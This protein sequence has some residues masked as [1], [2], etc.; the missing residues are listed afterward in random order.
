[1]CPSGA[2]RGRRRRLTVVG[3]SAATAVGLVVTVPALLSGV[4]RRANEVS[5]VASMLAIVA[6]VAGAALAGRLAGRSTQPHG[7]KRR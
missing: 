2:A 6:F 7:V 5:A 3:V 4:A 1:M